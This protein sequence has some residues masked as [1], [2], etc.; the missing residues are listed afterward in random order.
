MDHFSWSS[1]A[2]FRSM[3]TGGAEELK[4]SA[5]QTSTPQLLFKR[6]SS[7]NKHHYL[8]LCFKKRGES[9]EK[10]GQVVYLP[11]A[12]QCGCAVTEPCVKKAGRA[13]RAALVGPAHGGTW[14]PTLCTAPHLARCRQTAKHTWHGTCCIC[15]KR[16][17]LSILSDSD[18]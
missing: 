8:L 15:P 7:K 17:P 11:L 9:S 16:T 4:S 6:R 10:K 18:H 12:T 2:R 5:L 14:D 1:R 13:S 3:V